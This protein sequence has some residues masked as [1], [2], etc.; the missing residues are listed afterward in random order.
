MKDKKIVE[1]KGYDGDHDCP[2]DMNNKFI[3]S[4][5]I[6]KKYLFR[7]RPNFSMKDL[8]MDPTKICE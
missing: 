5:W 8:E 7:L 1:I 6:A 4:K 2:R 3:S